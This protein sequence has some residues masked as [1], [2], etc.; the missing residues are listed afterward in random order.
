MGTSVETRDVAIRG[1]RENQVASSE[2]G[3]FRLFG[4][5][6]VAIRI[7]GEVYKAVCGCVVEGFEMLL[8]IL[9][10]V[11]EYSVDERFKSSVYRVLV[12]G[13]I[14]KHIAEPFTAQSVGDSR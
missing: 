1:G 2:Q 12:F 4:D 6:I 3:G 14:P 8:D 7:R 13:A 10:G 5:L 9:L 11:K